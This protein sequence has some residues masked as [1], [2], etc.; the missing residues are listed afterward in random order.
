MY[1][2]LHEEYEIG[3][4]LE[5]LTN[6]PSYVPDHMMLK[7]WKSEFETIVLT[8]PKKFTSLVKPLD[9]VLTDPLRVCF[10][11]FS[12]FGSKAV[13]LVKKRTQ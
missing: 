6:S 10:I 11:R 9:V 12:I 8:I 13:L 4:N 5:V 2:K 1:R 3:V 7:D